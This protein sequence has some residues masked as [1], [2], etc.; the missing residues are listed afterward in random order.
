MRGLWLG[1]DVVIHGRFAP[2]LRPYAA[3]AAY[4]RGQGTGR[5]ARVHGLDEVLAELGPLVVEKRIPAP[6]QATTGP[7]EGEGFILVRHPETRVVR[8][9][10]ARIVSTVRVVLG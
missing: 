5:V 1:A 6:G 10:L 9:A 7:Y 4:L 2:R 8:A 3:G